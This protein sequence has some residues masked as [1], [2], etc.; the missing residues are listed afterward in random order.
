MITYRRGSRASPQGIAEA[1]RGRV[2]AQRT[3]SELA[4]GAIDLN[5]HDAWRWAYGVGGQARLSWYMNP[6]GTS[7]AVYGATKPSELL[8][9]SPT[10]RAVTA[11]VQPTCT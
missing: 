9:W 2:A 5:S 7:V 6:C 4:F 8:R 1:A 10:L 3:Y 11:S